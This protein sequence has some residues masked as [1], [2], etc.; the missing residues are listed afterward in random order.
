LPGTL[1]LR[2]LLTG[3]LLDAPLFGQLLG[4]LLFS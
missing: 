4:A 3:L 1:L 2:E